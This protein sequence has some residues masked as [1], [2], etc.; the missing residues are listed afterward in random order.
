MRVVVRF[1]P[2]VLAACLVATFVQKP[3]RIARAQDGENQ[4]IDEDEVKKLDEPYQKAREAVVAKDYKKAIE[5]LEVLFPRFE[6][7]KLPASIKK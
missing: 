5:A 7:A 4:K 6:K 2:A 1:A 3:V